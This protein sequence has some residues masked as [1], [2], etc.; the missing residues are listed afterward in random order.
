MDDYLELDYYRSFY[1]SFLEIKQGG[2]GN[3]R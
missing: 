3:V 2:E 1:I